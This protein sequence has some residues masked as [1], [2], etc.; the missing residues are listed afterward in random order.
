M[1]PQL[2][3]FLEIMV[4]CCLWEIEPWLYRKTTVIHHGKSR[5]HLTHL[6]PWT[7][8]VLSDLL[9]ALKFCTC[10]DESQRS[11]PCCFPGLRPGIWDM[12]LWELDIEHLPL[13]IDFN[14]VAS[15]RDIWE[16]IERMWHVLNYVRCKANT[17]YKYNLDVTLYNCLA[18][19]QLLR[20]KEASILFLSGA[21]VCACVWMWDTQTQIISEP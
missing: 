13:C 6:F 11:R 18:M 19:D 2:F 14:N 17:I 10:G 21:S 5:N 20:R 1:L 4:A 7:G 12:P 8:S 9:G 3:C 16:Q 15:L